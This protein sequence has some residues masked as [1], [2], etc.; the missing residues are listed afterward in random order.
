MK[1]WLLIVVVVFVLLMMSVYVFIP[2][3]LTIAEALKISCTVNGTNRFLMNDSNWVK[4]WPGEPYTRSQVLS[5]HYNKLTYQPDERFYNK[6]TVLIQDDN[7]GIQSFINV[8]PLSVDSMQVVWQTEMKTAMNPLIRLQQYLFARKLKKDLE[9]LMLRLKTF[10]EKTENVYGYNI[11]RATVQKAYVATVTT[12]YNHYPSTVEIYSLINKLNQFVANNDATVINYPMLNISGADSSGF[13]AMVGLATN[14]ELTGKG[15]IIIKNLVT[16]KVLATRIK[17]G[18]YKI[19]QALIQM[20]TY[21]N[22]YHLFSPAIPFQ[23]LITDRLQEPDS[24]K[25]ITNV[26]YPLL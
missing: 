12:R 26:Y 10:L 9:K 1:K 11:Q 20:K 5:L 2:S 14:K 18:T 21:L 16:D 17:G 19:E 15:N 7:T 8:L 23:S 22:D 25:W 13:E 4:W 24:S 3:K 6:R